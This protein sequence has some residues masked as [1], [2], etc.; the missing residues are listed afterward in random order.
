MQQRVGLARALATG[1]E[2]LLF[3]EPFSALDPLIRRD[4]QD[5]VTR[6]R[7]QV[8]TTMMF[9]THDLAEALRLGDR[10]AIMRDGRFVQVGTPA[11][12]VGSPADD[13]V[14]N[15]VRDVSRSHVLAVESIMTPVDG[16]VP[17]GFSARVPLGTKVRDV[18]GRLAHNDLPVGVV[19]GEGRIVGTV[20]RVA[21]LRLVAG[22][23]VIDVGDGDGD[24]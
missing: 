1:P 3:D 6:L 24:G 23:D 16:V 5:E 17:D 13:Y 7:R 18:L 19:D 4:M 8:N 10:I 15:F 21:A 20:D 22:E 14:E 11:E 2:V 12:V 9:I